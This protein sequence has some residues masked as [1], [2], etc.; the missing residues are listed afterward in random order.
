[1][2]VLITGASGQVGRNL[3]ALAPKDRPVTGVTRADLDITDAPAVEA[4]VQELRPT[5]MINA[6]AYTAVDA[7]EAD[8]QAAEAINT[9]AVGTLAAAAAGIGSQF[10]HISTD[11]VFDGHASKAY[12]PDAPTNPLSA[13]GRTKRDGELRALEHHPS[14]LIVRTAWVY[15]AEGRNFVR[16]MLRLMGEREGLR[17]VA[18]QIGTPTAAASLA[19]ALWRLAE[20]NAAGMVH[21]TD[22]GVASWYDFAIAIQE[23]AVAGGL[24]A[25][26]IPIEP[27]A[28]RD[29]PT[30]A[31]R[32]AFS[33]LDTAS[34]R[35][36]LGGAPDHWRVSLR[37][38]LKDIATHG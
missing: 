35:A 22:S 7:A 2:S 18:D 32:P 30:P 26:A 10:V 25:K 12:A 36:H 11:F 17:V 1:M 37:R 29:Y 4:M 27:I 14:A 8:T 31:P 19:S 20:T 13:Y 24:L 6:A 21:Y 9:G 28:T 3:L 15:D 33:V 38:V 34:A 16:T 23:E 5:L